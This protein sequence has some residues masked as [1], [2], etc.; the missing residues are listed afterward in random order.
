MCI[1]R[2]DFH[3]DV[4][5][6]FGIRD[7]KFDRNN[8]SESRNR[9]GILLFRYIYKSGQRFGTVNVISK[10]KRKLPKIRIK[11]VKLNTTIELDKYT[12]TTI[13]RC[14]INGINLTKRLVKRLIHRISSDHVHLYRLKSF[15]YT[16]MYAWYLGTG[17]VRTLTA[18]LN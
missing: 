5:G 15:I 10:H 17:E 3:N 6:F 1:E 14:G 16:R 18:K 12:K 13:I 2:N 9:L 4:M 11:S 8:R 7:V